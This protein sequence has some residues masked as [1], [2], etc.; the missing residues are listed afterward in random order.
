MM[1]NV[2]CL[3]WGTKYSPDYVNRLY[4]MVKRHLHIPFD[5]Y[6]MTE[7]AQDIRSEV[8]IL[9][10]PALGLTGW[11]YKLYLFSTDF[12]GLSGQV[13]FLDLDVVITDSLAAL[14]TYS[15]EK[16]CIAQDQ[17]VGKYNSSVMCFQIGSLDYIWHSFWHQREKVMTSFHGD[18][19]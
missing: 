11:W 8:K 16:L 18:Q 13:L 4:G 14:T 2:I 5:F 10:L 19:D 7:N 6:C 12:Y 1:L 17:E 15:P 9:P 3:K